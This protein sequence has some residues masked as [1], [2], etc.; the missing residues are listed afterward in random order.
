MA[1]ISTIEAAERLKISRRRILTLIQDGRLR[2]QKLGPMWMVEEKDLHEF[3][4]KPRLPGRPRKP[5][6]RGK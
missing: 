1:I 6:G 4:E 2:A 5:K 3:E